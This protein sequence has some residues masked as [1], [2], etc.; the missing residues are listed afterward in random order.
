MTLIQKIEKD[1]KKYSIELS[2]LKENRNR[3]L[4]KLSDSE[5]QDY[6]NQIR[7]TCRILTDLKSIR[8]LASLNVS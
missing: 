7:L 3:D 4:D 8:E 1:I 5:L 2:N 6:E